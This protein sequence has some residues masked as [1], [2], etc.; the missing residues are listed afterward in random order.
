MRSVNRPVT[1][2]APQ[3]TSTPDMP[4]HIASSCTEAPR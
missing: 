4:T 2:V 1:M 3:L